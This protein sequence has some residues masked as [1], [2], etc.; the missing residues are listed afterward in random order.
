MLYFLQQFSI[1]AD[2][3][4][5]MLYFL[6]D[7]SRTSQEKRSSLKAERFFFAD[8]SCSPTEASAGSVHILERANRLRRFRFHY[9]NSQLTVGFV[10]RHH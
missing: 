2:L 6:Q 3:L 5:K 10:N 1:W 8:C 4:K 9:S 7:L